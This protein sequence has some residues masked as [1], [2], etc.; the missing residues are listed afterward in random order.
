MQS[1]LMTLRLLLIGA[2]D[3][4]RQVWAQGSSRCSMPIEF[5]STDMSDEV[6]ARGAIDVCIVDAG[7][8]NAARAGVVQMARMMQPPPLVVIAGG[9]PGPRQAGIDGVIPRPSHAMEA[10]RYVDTCIRARL[11][12][13]TLIVDDSSTM[14]HIVRKILSASRFRMAIEEADD[15]PAALRQ[16]RAGGYGMIFL[17]YNMPGLNGFETLRELRREHPDL[18]VVMITSSTD[19]GVADRARAAGAFGFLKKPF[20]PADID[21]VLERYSGLNGE[22]TGAPVRA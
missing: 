14:R 10:A 21:A 15:G 9:G 6:L 8:S 19:D 12:T 13:R 7:L 5:F 20:Y 22:P 1:D 11:P 17:D 3:A 18:A 4:Q 16:V 2:S